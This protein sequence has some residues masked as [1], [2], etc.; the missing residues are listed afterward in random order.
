MSQRIII[1]LPDEFIA[2]CKEDGVE[3]ETVLRGFIADLAEIVNWA[4]DPRKDGYSSNGSD[5]RRMAREYYERVGY[6]YWNTWK[7]D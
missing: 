2:V 4:N 6:P 7:D 3:P 1:D 5:E